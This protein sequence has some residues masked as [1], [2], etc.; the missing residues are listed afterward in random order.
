MGCRRLITCIHFD[1]D[2]YIWFATA[3]ETGRFM[4]EASFISISTL[5]Q[6]A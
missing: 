1:P 5:S 2:G 4:A 3:R 6:A